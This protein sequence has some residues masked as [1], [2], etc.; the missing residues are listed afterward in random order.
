MEFVRQEKAGVIATVVGWAD[1][2]KS[3]RKD[4]K[5]QVMF[6]GCKKS[7]QVPELGIYGIITILNCLF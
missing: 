6:T 1:E 7:L 2:M 3:V 4:R 5:R